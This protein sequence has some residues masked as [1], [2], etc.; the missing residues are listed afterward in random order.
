MSLQHGLA[1]S[2]DSDI[3][4]VIASQGIEWWML[5]AFQCGELNA[6]CCKPIESYDDAGCLK[7]G[8]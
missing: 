2:A 7:V 5:C 8:H 3:S 1:G 4:Y 6:C